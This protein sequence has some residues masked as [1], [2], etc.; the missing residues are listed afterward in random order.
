MLWQI[1]KNSLYERAGIVCRLYI[2]KKQK[3]TT[4][5]NS[6]QHKPFECHDLLQLHEHW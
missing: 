1:L 2:K 6:V 5:C 4:I 3:T